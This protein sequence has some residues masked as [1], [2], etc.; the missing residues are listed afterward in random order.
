MIKL[1]DLKTASIT[2]IIIIAMLLALL[3]GVTD[4]YTGREISFSIFYLLPILLVT[5]YARK[6]IGIYFSLLSSLEWL[7]ADQLTNLNYSHFTV[8]FWNMLVR[9]SFFLIIVLIVSRLKVALE[10]E[11]RI[12]RTDPLT[13]VSNSRFFYEFA[14]VEVDRANRYNHFLTI[15]YIDLDNFK[16]LNDNFGHVTGDRLLKMVAESL[17]QNKRKMDLIARLGGDEFVL[18][19]PEITNDDALKV[20]NRMKNLLLQ[21]MEKNKWPV[22]FSI[23]L[24]TYQQ[25]PSSIDIMVREADD[26]MYAAKQNGK[27]QMESKELQG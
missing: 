20:V 8:P 23:G 10:R 4:Y 3:V 2:S 15:V 17:F 5:W 16:Y 1:I 27:N 11:K 9:L 12:S 14:S 6:S 13:G 25:P 22:T 21:V 19:L 7:I 24:V 18:L 26:L